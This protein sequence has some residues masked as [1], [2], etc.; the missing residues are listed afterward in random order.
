MI[1]FMCHKS[2]VPEGG[3]F[4]TQLWNG[5]YLCHVPCQ[6]KFYYDNKPLEKDSDETTTSEAPRS[7]E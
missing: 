4:K 1:C 3:Y 2:I 5:K 7:T 6:P